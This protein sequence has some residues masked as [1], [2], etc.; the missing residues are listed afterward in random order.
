MERAVIKQW[1]ADSPEAYA[2]IA[3]ELFDCLPMPAFVA[4][5]A[6][7]GAG[8]TTFVRAL[9]ETA[10]CPHFEGSPTFAIVQSYDTP[11]YG[12]IYHLDCYRIENE[13]DLEQ[14]GLDELFDELAYFFVEWPQNVQSILPQQCFWLYIRIETDLSRTLILC[15][16]H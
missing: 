12:L 6:P 16:D 2:I 1:K 15:H 10:A 8:K 13:R 14:L 11:T 4:I 3:K 7:M 9:L 5:E